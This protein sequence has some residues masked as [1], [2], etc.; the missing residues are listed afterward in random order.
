MGRAR[1]VLTSPRLAILTVAYHSGDRYR[2]F[3]SPPEKS[4]TMTITT[5]DTTDWVLLDRAVWDAADLTGPADGLPRVTEVLRGQVSYGKAGL[6]LDPDFFVTNSEGFLV[7]DLDAQS[8]N[9]GGFI[10]WRFVD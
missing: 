9:D 5:N 4:I 10:V 6:I 7:T 1:E 2:R 3:V 8:P